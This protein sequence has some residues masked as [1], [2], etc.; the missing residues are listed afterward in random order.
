MP[1]ATL[2]TSFTFALLIIAAVQLQAMKNNHWWMVPRL[3]LGSSMG[4]L[5]GAITIW[6]LNSM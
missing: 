1:Q 3:V 5:L 2:L 6:V 4:L